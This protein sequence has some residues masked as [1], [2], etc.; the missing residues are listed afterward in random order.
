[1]WGKWFVIKQTSYSD[2]VALIGYPN[3]QQDLSALITFSSQGSSCLSPTYLLI[4]ISA[5]F[6]G[7]IPSHVAARLTKKYWVPNFRRHFV[8]IPLHRYL[9]LFVN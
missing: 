2:N 4:S 7:E 6:S 3:K 5:F 9:P 8:T 1:M